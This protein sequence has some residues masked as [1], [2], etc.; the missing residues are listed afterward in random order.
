MQ[1][2]SATLVDAKELKTVVKKFKSSK[3]DFAMGSH[4]LQWKA[5]RIIALVEDWKALKAGNDMFIIEYTKR[6]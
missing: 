5:W 1:N 2:L 6:W 3:I 4:L